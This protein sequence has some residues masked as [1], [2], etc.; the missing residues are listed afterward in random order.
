[1]IHSSFQSQYNDLIQLHNTIFIGFGIHRKEHFLTWHRWYVLQYEN[2]LRRVDCKVTV[3]Y[4]DWTVVSGTPWGSTSRDV[5]Y[6]GNSGLGG[7]GVAPTRCVKDGPFRDEIWNLLPSVPA[8]RCLKRNFV[9]KPPD[10]VALAMLLNTPVSK[11]HEFELTLRTTFHD[12]VHC[13]IDGT[14]C[15]FNSSGAPEFFLHHGMV[16]KVSK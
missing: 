5:W 12:A 1:M 14:M 13:L 4:W 6:S 10:S 16:D 9:G 7:N 2:L 15:G 11:F 3:P 8:P